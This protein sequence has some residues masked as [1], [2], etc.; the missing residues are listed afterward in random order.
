MSPCNGRSGW[1]KCFAFF[2]IDIK[3]VSAVLGAR[4]PHHLYHKEDAC[5]KG[6]WHLITIHLHCSAYACGERLC[7]ILR[8]HLIADR[9][10]GRRDVRT[11]LSDRLWK[12]FFF[13]R[14]ACENTVPLQ[15]GVFELGIRIGFELPQLAF[16]IRRPSS[17][18]RRIYCTIYTI[19]LTFCPNCERTALTWLLGRFACAFVMKPLHPSSLYKNAFTVAPVLCFAPDN[20]S[21]NRLLVRH[22]VINHI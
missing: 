7:L 4:A 21:Y 3:K 16:A 6:A 1:H 17:H 18:S 14:Q 10:R 19:Y 12:C 2:L 20:H 9:I 15:T 5:R 22:W 8:F 13:F 11:S